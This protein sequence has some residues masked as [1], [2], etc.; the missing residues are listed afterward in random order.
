MSSNDPSLLYIQ[1]ITG[2]LL[3]ISELLG[4]SS[5][6]YNGVFH[7]IFLFCNRKIHLDCFMEKQEVIEMQNSEGR[8]SKEDSF[9]SLPLNE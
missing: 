7:F 2:A 1:I 4:F 9:H 3:F 8:E 6:E 5:C